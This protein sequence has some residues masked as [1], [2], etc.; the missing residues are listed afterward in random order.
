MVMTDYDSGAILADLLTSRS[1]TELLH[2]VTKFYEQLKERGLKLR[3]HILDNECSTLM[4]NFIREAGATHQLVPPGL[5]QAL[6]AD[7]EIQAFKAH[8]IAGL[9]SCDP[10]CFLR[11]WDCLI[12]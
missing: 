9:S 10:K 5:H 2:T 11:L 3:L 8:L 12:R 1:K 4:K 7:R 6:I